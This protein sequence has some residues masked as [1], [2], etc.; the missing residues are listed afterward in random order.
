QEYF[1]GFV[2][3]PFT[4]LAWIKVASH[5][6]APQVEAAACKRLADFP[7]LSGFESALCLRVKHNDPAGLIM[8]RGAQL[9]AL[10]FQT[11]Q[12]RELVI[13]I[14]H[15]SLGFERLPHDL[16]SGPRFGVDRACKDGEMAGPDCV[17]MRV[18]G[19]LAQFVQV[20]D[21]ADITMFLQASVAFPAPAGF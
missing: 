11:D 4:A 1:G 5:A 6:I 12:A 3:I 17:Q 2:N 13:F 18:D 15:Q 8:E 20:L 21:L 9:Q 10:R 7:L 16:C 14:C 19:L